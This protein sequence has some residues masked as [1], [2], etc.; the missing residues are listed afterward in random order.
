MIEGTTV[1]RMQDLSILR[2]CTE[3]VIHQGDSKHREGEL[4]GCKPTRPLCPTLE[5]QIPKETIDEMELLND[6]Y[7]QA[8]ARRSA[9]R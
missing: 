9:V 8:H 2:S 5:K 6:L 7:S 3:V 4:G 1:K